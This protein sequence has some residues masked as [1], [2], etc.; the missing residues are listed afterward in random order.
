MKIKET[1]SIC[2]SEYCT[3][4]GA[5]LKHI[6]K[7]HNIKDVGD[8][9]YTSN[10][11]DFCVVCGIKNKR[12][13]NWMFDKYKTC[14]DK[15]CIRTNANSIIGEKQRTLAISGKHNSQSIEARE[16]ARNRQL[17]SFSNGTHVSQCIDHLEKLSTATTKR[18]L[19]KNPMHD[20]INVE[21]MSKSSMGKVLTQEH[22]DKISKGLSAYLSS[23][24]EEEFTKRMRNTENISTIADNT[25]YYP[26]VDLTHIFENPEFYIQ[27]TENTI[28]F[29]KANEY[30]CLVILRDLKIEL[31]K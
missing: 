27:K 1:C 12:I 3:Q 7:A 26:H 20:K 28:S 23:L 22:R 6:N 18:N 17:Q 15:I 25:D 9:Y 16:K 21:K 14:E 2:N 31:E 10:K 29:G 19:E 5:M 8:Y 4:S 30:N 24:S 11:A 13:K